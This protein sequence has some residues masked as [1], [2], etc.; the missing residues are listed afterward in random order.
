FGRLLDPFGGQRHLEQRLII[1][2]QDPGKTFSDDPLRMMRAI[3]FAAQLDFRIAPETFT[4]IREHRAR[5][6]IVSQE[7][8]TDELHKILGSPKPSVGFDLLFR[9]GLLQQFFPKLADLSGAE[10][11]DG[12]G[13]KDNFY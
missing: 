8:I 13:H 10:Y 5:I 7:R 11:R 9:S 3:R 1:T 12:L 6:R 4:A 2:P